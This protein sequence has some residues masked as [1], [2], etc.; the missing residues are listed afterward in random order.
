MFKPYTT[1][2][3]SFTLDR[4]IGSEG[5]NSKAFV[6]YD[7]QLGAEI[8]IKQV[9]KSSLNSVT[10][11]FEEA[12]CQ[13][14]GSHPNVV[15]IHYACED[16]EHIYLGMPFY[17]NGSLKTLM[18]ERA[19]TVRDIAVFGCQILSGLHNIHV[20][21]LIHFDIKPDNVLL[22]DNREA[23]LSDFGLAKQMP[24]GIAIQNRHYTI[25]QPPEAF[26]TNQFDARFDIF[27]FGLTLYRMCNS[28][29]VFYSQLTPFLAQTEH[30][31]NFTEKTR[32]EFKV[33]VEN[34]LFPCR[35]TFPPHIPIRLKRIIRKCIE[36][37]ISDRYSSALE[38]A[39]ELAKIDGNCLDW[40]FSAEYATRVWTKTEGEKHQ[41]LTID[42]DSNSVLTKRIGEGTT[43]RVGNACQ[44][45]LSEHQ[46]HRLLGGN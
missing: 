5:R 2:Q 33:A 21:G 45:N 16:E 31:L 12:K 36:P 24:T 46:I 38:V 17:K 8:V 29:P 13:Y 35:Q 43:R 25:M 19:L 27:Q 28:D 15:E 44:T 14:A 3:L 39:N 37:D 6:A 42:A 30:G 40:Q 41:V 32:Q 26:I 34:G 4:E 9:E 11:Y 23:L 22:A 20:N 1:A 7:G 10:D 18:T